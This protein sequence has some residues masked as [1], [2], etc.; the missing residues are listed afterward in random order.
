MASDQPPA[1]PKELV[2]VIDVLENALGDLSADRVTALG[3]S[4]LD[5]LADAVNAF[6]EAWLSPEPGADE[7]RFYSGGSETVTP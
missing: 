1:E 7:L 6:Y 3:T 4:Q 5:E 2:S